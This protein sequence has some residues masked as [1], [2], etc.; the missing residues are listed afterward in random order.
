MRVTKLEIIESTNDQFNDIVL[1]L[2][3]SGE[4][5]YEC[6]KNDIQ[7]IDTHNEIEQMKKE[8]ENTGSMIFWDLHLMIQLENKIVWINKVRLSNE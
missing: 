3:R 4:M 1:N 8:Y 6:Y 5:E 7:V 2:V